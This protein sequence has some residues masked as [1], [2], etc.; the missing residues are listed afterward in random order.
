MALPSIA[1]PEFTTK[2]PSTGQEIRYRPFL[3]KEQKILLMAMEG[4]DANEIMVS[5]RNILS[6]CILSD[7]VNIDKLSTFDVEYLFLKLRSKSVGEV[8][9]IK[10]NHPEGSECKYL[11]EVDVNVDAVEIR[12]EVKNGKI[13]LTDQIGLKL[14]Y[15]TM[16]DL[17]GVSLDDAESMFKMVRKCI[18]YIFDQ[19]D[20]YADFSE[21]ELTEWI[22]GLNQTQFGKI[23]EFFESM[24][25]LSHTIE[26]E[27]KSCGNKDSVTVEGL[28]GFFI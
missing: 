3:V 19:D 12:G 26:W 16:N 1:T 20:V 6:N 5:V 9:K 2:I 27:C 10:V 8:I 4:K 11:S 18:E 21:K 22:E 25:K 7:D 17:K 13:M 28:Q 23:T 15:P 14:R 24:P